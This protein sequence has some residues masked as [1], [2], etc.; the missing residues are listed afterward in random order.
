MGR[1]CDLV[2][3]PHCGYR[4]AERSW[5]VEFFKKLMKRRRLHAASAS[6]R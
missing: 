4:F 6:R 5:V 3:C 1:G 2:R